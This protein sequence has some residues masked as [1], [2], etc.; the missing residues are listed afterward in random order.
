M[1]QLFKYISYKWKKKSGKMNNNDALI[2]RYK[3]QYFGKMYQWVRPIN[4]EAVGDVVRVVDVKLRGDMVL[5]VF[6]AGTP[7]S[8]SLV[9]SYLKP[10]SDPGMPSVRTGEHDYQGMPSGGPI[11][12]P[13]E[14]KDFTT[15]KQKIAFSSPAASQ[16]QAI[17]EAKKAK[18]DLFAQFQSEEKDISLK[19]KIK[20][21]DI[22]LI[23]MMYNNAADKDK[24]L[25]ELSEYVISNISIDMAKDAIRILLGDT[26]AKPIENTEKKEEQDDRQ[27]AD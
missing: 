23:T 11:A 24:F 9:D 13:D 26:A 10:I 4:N 25:I 16:N 27:T 8:A 20:I 19:I 1:I 3:D 14:L 22:A 18:T 5:L 17:Q 12:I 6:N 15:D 7:I 21:P 2:Q